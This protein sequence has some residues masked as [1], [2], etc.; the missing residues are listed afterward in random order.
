MSSWSSVGGRPIGRGRAP[1]EAASIAGNEI[2]SLAAYE[3]PWLRSRGRRN[4]PAWWTSR[5]STRISR[6]LSQDGSGTASNADPGTI[7]LGASS[8]TGI[9]SASPT[10]RPRRSK[11]SRSSGG[12][13]SNQVKIRVLGVHTLLQLHLAGLVGDP[14]G[15]GLVVEEVRPIHHRAHHTHVVEIHAVIVQQRNL[16]LVKQHIQLR[17]VADTVDEGQ[18]CHVRTCAGASCRPAL[19]RSLP[20]DTRDVPQY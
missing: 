16:P 9:T 12:T 4:P 20:T 13:S 14:W 10:S 5:S 3:P 8:G 11:K 2:A 6:H 1:A 7:G 17:L 19:R 15:R 18:V